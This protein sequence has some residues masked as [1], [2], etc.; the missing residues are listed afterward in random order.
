MCARTS[1]CSEG[2]ASPNSQFLNRR[3]SVFH[4]SREWR[5]SCTLRN[6]KTQGLLMFLSLL[7]FVGFENLQKAFPQ[8]YWPFP[9]VKATSIAPRDGSFQRGCPG[10]SGGL[11]LP[12]Y[13]LVHRVSHLTCMHLGIGQRWPTLQAEGS[14]AFYS[15]VEEGTLA[16]AEIV[17]FCT[18]LKGP[19]ALRA[20]GWPP[21]AVYSL[22][23]P[24]F[25]ASCGERCW[26]I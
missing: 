14:W 21:P 5:R 19:V 4:S 10:F 11:S 2:D 12:G 26:I 23:V 16:G 9:P 22:T 6:F 15:C 1:G 7:I 25:R 18:T 3:P 17:L 24:P 20:R 8:K 13:F